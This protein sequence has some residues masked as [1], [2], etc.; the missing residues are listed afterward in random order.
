MPRK[1]LDT[2]RAQDTGL[3]AVIA[4]LAMILVA[5]FYV[6][7]VSDSET[8]SQTDLSGISLTLKAIQGDLF[9]TKGRLD[10]LDSKFATLNSRLETV[11]MAGA[12]ANISLPGVAECLSE[13]SYAAAECYEPQDA[14]ASL[15]F[16]SYTA[17]RTRIDTCTRSCRPVA[18]YPASC[19]SSCSMALFACIKGRGNSLD[20]SEVCKQSNEDC[21]TNLC[22]RNVPGVNRPSLEAP[23]AADTCVNQCERGYAICSQANRFDPQKYDECGWIR[24]A[25]RS[26]VC[27]GKPI[28]TKPDARNIV[29]ENECT[30][31]F[32]ACR[33]TAGDNLEALEACNSGYGSC[34]NQC[35]I[36]SGG[37]FGI[38][39]ENPTAPAE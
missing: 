3:G 24:D 39:S 27:E 33:D 7:A 25:C 20:V 10:S 28:T 23:L 13:C 11:Y 30:Q 32:T 18:T 21:L 36:Q 12:D 4:A 8:P 38:D 19:D 35:L 5:P 22:P 34:R 2:K 14:I 29:C 9:D 17:C 1:K 15:E 31:S 26:N 16:T 37:G 6:Y